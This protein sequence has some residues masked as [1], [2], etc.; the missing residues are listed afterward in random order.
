MFF[1]NP[2]EKKKCK[3]ITTSLLVGATILLTAC[4]SSNDN[5]NAEI[6]NTNNVTQDYQ[7]NV[8]NF[9]ERSKTLNPMLTE[10]DLK[11]HQKKSDEFEI[12]EQDISKIYQKVQMRYNQEKELEAKR[13]KESKQ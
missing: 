13:A 6:T 4:S 12:S 10:A 9:K 3:K 7:F 5:T 2:Q 1:I 11:D 8:N